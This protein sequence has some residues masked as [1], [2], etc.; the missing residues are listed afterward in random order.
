MQLTQKQ[1]A[2]AFSSGNFQST[3]PYLSKHIQWSVINNFECIGKK[4]VIAQ[5]DKTTIYFASISTEFKQIDVIECDTKVVITGTAD[6]SKNGTHIEFIS[7][8]DVYEFSTDTMLLKI[9]SYCL[10]ENEEQH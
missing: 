1:I 5:C 9:T 4:E 3:Y 10:I 7:A 6:L 2:Q 8:C